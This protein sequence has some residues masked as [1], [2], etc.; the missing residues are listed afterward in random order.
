[1]KQLN[2]Y[3]AGWRTR[4]YLAKGIKY[5]KYHEIMSG[6]LHYMRL[7]RFENQLLLFFRI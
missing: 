3:Y 4:I 7:D 1:M 6:I 2:L 5:A